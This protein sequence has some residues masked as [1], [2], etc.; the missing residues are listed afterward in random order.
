[1]GDLV[2]DMLAHLKAEETRDNPVRKRYWLFGGANFLQAQGGMKDFK[3]QFDKV[4]AAH[5]Q[6]EKLLVD[7]KRPF[8][9]PW[10]HILDSYTGEIG[11]VKSK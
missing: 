1:M 5:E 4:E 9:N 8:S 10:A 6:A 3:G 11:E 7:L 2:Q